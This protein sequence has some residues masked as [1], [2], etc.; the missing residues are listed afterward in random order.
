[1]LSPEE[2][3]SL[4]ESI[5]VKYDNEICSIYSIISDSLNEQL[6]SW[7]LSSSPPLARHRTLPKFYGSLMT[8]KSRSH[9]CPF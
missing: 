8:Y 6:N 7:D 4:N 5:P 2:Q 9:Y 3:K 1:M